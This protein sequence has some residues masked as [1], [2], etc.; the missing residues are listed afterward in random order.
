[1]GLSGA[2]RT[3]RR[4]EEENKKLVVCIRCDAEMPKGA[5]CCK[6]CDATDLLPKIEFLKQAREAKFARMRFQAESRKIEKKHFEAKRDYDLARRLRR[7][8]PCDEIYDPE[9]SYCT[10][11]GNRTERFTENDAKVT[12][13]HK[14]SDIIQSDGDLEYID[15]IDPSSEGT[16]TDSAISATKEVAKSAIK[17]GWKGTKAT[18][19]RLLK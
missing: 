17:I 11:C 9:H 14:Y 8:I 13:Y 5:R 4:I 1:M 12:M 19:R 3:L 18:L 10:K 6:S 16:F 15:A 7:C 2:G